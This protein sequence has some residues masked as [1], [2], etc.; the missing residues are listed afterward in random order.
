MATNK[1]ATGR[2]SQDDITSIIHEKLVEQNI[3]KKKTLSKTVWK[4][5]LAT[6]T[7][8]LQKGN[9]VELHGI[10]T[11]SLRGRDAYIGRNPRTRTSQKVEA[12][13]SVGFVPSSVLKKALNPK[14]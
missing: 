14:K 12:K 6:I 11:L 3:N 5:A 13:I 4:A 10:G 7:D 1:I 8:L 2:A 9:D